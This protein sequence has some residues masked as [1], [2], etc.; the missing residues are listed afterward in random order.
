M[1]EEL[2]IELTPPTEPTAH[3]HTGTEQPKISFKN[4]DGLI[5]VVSA[6]PTSTPNSVYNQIKLFVSG[7][8]GTICIYDYTEKEWK[9]FAMN[10]NDHGDLGGL[11]DND[12]PQYIEKD[13]TTSDVSADIPFNNNKLTGVKD[14]TANQDAVTKKYVDDEVAGTE[15]VVSDTVRHSND[16]IVINTTDDATYYK[17]KEIK[18]NEA[19]DAVRVKF[20]YYQIS[21]QS[22]QWVAL[23]KNGGL[24]EE[25]ELPT[26]TTE[27]TASRDLSSVAVNDLIQVYSK[28][29]V[30]NESVRVKN[31]RLHFLKQLVQPSD[32]TNQDP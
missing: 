5:E 6:V 30:G 18:I 12:H 23:Y 14:P 10:T 8:D 22:E 9:E 15:E 16:A 19:V 2:T 31:F 11:A 32:F 20:V 3:R 4:L 7:T 27:R 26:D 1:A 17:Q 13:G 21:S 28:L 29:R 25:W 24:L